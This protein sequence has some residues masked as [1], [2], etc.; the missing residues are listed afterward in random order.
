[1]QPPPLNDKPQPPAPDECCESGC[2]PCVWDIYRTE[3]QKW[4]QAQQA[5]QSTTPQPAT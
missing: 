4:E 1:M 5:P 2:A 3:L